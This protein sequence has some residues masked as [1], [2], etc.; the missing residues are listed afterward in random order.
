MK[1]ILLIASVTLAISCGSNNQQQ[2]VQAA[3][4]QAKQATLDSVNAVAQK[5]KTIDLLQKIVVKDSVQQ[6][7]KHQEE[8]TPS[9]PSTSSASNTSVQP[10]ATTTP[11][12]HKK[13]WN[14]TTKGAVIG[15]G[16]GGI[17]GALVSKHK[18]TGALIGTALGAGAGAGTGAI[19]DNNKK[20]KEHQ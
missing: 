8:S 15:A 4:V 11:A 14:S 3:A 13:G 10:V 19:I 9:Q 5:Q 18:V 17:T 6:Q 20:K 2:A 7:A 12:H 1:K 16:A